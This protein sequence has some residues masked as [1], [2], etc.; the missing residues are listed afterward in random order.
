MRILRAGFSNHF[1]DR[2]VTV[3]CMHTESTSYGIHMVRSRFRH[4][5]KLAAMFPDDPRR[6]RLYLRDFLLPRFE[7]LFIDYG[8]EAAKSFDPA[9]PEIVGLLRTF[10]EAVEAN[11]YV[12]AWHKR[13]LRWTI[14]LVSNC[15]P[16][17][18]QFIGRLTRFPGVRLA[19]RLLG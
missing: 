10:A 13:K 2:T 15:S 6:G 1:C 17:M 12:S 7:R 3:W 8:I 11:P 19:R 5:H 14:S 18:V 9:R 16:G 4:F